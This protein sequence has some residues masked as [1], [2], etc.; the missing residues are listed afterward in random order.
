[1]PDY[2]EY[3][4]CDS[5][6]M[7]WALQMTGECMSLLA[8]Q[9]GIAEVEDLRRYEKLVRE[10]HRLARLQPPARYTSVQWHG[11][12]S[13]YVIRDPLCPGQPP[14]APRLSDA[15][16]KR[17]WGREVNAQ[18]ERRRKREREDR[19]ARRAAKGAESESEQEDHEEDSDCDGESYDP[20][21]CCVC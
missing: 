18:V 4:A 7:L 3:W 17:K 11:V 20:N 6:P 1:M 12:M 9:G 15:A 21:E 5:A 16:L 14:A 13:L 10:W 2:K 8:F 19:M